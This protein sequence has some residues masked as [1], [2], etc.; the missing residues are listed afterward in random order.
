[1]KKIFLCT[2]MLAALL[3]CSCNKEVKE[4]EKDGSQ[5]ISAEISNEISNEGANESAE[6][7]AEVKYSYAMGMKSLEK[8]EGIL[9]IQGVSISCERAELLTRAEALFD[10]GNT[11]V[12]LVLDEGFTIPDANEQLSDQGYR[13]E[14]TDKI[15]ITASTEV[16]LYYG[17]RTVSDYIKLQGCMEKGVYTDWPDV[18]ERTLHLDTARKYFTKDFII[19]M[20]EEVSALKMNAVELH[21]SENEGFRI[22]CDTD[23]AIVSDDYL[24][25]DEVREIISAAKE[26]YVEIIPSFDSPGHLLQI[27][28][29]HP[30]YTLTDVDGYNSPKTL[31]ITNPDAIAYIKSLLDEYAELFADCKSFNIGGDE[32][33]GWSN[34]DRMQ[35][36]AWK[37]L[38]DYAKATYGEDANAHDAFLGYINDIAKHLTDK[39]FAVRAWNDGLLRTVG[40]AAVLKP[41]AHIDICFWTVGGVLKAED[42]SEFIENGHKIYNVNEQYMYYVLK[43]DYDQPKA[44]EIFKNWNAGVFTGDS[45]NYKNPEQVGDRLQGAYFCIWCDHPNTQSSSAVKANSARPMA[46]MA[47]KSWNAKPHVAYSDFAAQFNSLIG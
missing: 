42:V 41:S 20:I 29:V 5:Q 9:P 34:V 10:K 1:M 38:E 35:F 47:V 3:L 27:L 8:S 32:S 16:G 18:A 17:T 25:K 37:V 4:P 26:L 7:E 12:E 44:T 36:S 24:T 31:D 46:A 11:A 13:I 28:S 15:T 30:E 22:Q 6:L 33:F 23:P 21:F 43:E 14:V 2:L 19:D 40:Q 39:G 45:G